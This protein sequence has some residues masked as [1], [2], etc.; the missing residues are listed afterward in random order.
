MV[1]LVRRMNH[2][3]KYNKKMHTHKWYFSDYFT[4]CMV[5]QF[6]IH[7]TVDYVGLP[8]FSEDEKKKNMVPNLNTDL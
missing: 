2:K 6:L 3:D 8:I 7:T 4:E 5:C 1:V